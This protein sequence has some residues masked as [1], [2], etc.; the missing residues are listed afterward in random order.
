MNQSTRRDPTNFNFIP[1]TSAHT[2]SKDDWTEAYR[3]SKDTAKQLRVVGNV[4]VALQGNVAGD[5]IDLIVDN[6]HN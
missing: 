5:L 6:F 3:W 1:F 2:I 4:Y